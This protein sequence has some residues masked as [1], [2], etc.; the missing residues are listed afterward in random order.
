MTDSPSGYL[1][2]IKEVI[3]SDG[4][5]RWDKEKEQIPRNSA[6][7]NVYT[8]IPKGNAKAIV[9]NFSF[10]RLLIAD[11]SIFFSFLNKY[12]ISSSSFDEPI[13]STLL[14]ENSSSNIA[15]FLPLDAFHIPHI[16]L[17]EIQTT[18]CIDSATPIPVTPTFSPKIFSKQLC[19]C[20]SPC[21]SS[22]IPNPPSA[23]AV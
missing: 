19:K 7:S 14:A 21:A 1:K 22:I 8:L 6:T 4:G 13:T 5:L 16:F 11:L 17:V 10:S 20:K 2:S 9:N 12:A 3:T 23:E 15:I 18:V